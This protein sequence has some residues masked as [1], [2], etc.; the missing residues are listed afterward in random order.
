MSKP[1]WER[2]IMDAED[3]I[4][5]AKFRIRQLKAS[6]VVFKERMASGAPFPGTATAETPENSLRRTEPMPE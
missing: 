6:V 2:A 3:E 4:K 1:S 5:R